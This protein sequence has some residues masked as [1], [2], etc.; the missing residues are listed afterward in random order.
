MLV[1]S[2]ASS[3]LQYASAWRAYAISYNT[4]ASLEPVLALPLTNT[5]AT[6]IDIVSVAAGQLYFSHQAFVLAGR[7]KDVGALLSILYIA[8]LSLFILEGVF[9]CAWISTNMPALAD[10]GL[11]VSSLS[12][13][14]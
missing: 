6:L 2:I 10:D 14:W 9:L 7:R 3:I 1:C 12:H 11:Q 13:W 4:A 5:L 8:E